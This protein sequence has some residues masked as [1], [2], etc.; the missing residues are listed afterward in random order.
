MGPPSIGVSPVVFRLRRAALPLVL[1]RGIGR[2]MSAEQ[3]AAIITAIKTSGRLMDEDHVHLARALL[4]LLE[5]RDEY[6]VDAEE[7][8]IQA[9]ASLALMGTDHVSQ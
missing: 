3:L 8:L 9:L 4:I 5:R 7:A 1:G 2:S 6:P